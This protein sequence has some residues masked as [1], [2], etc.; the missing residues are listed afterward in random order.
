MSHLNKPLKI[1]LKIIAW[2]L[3]VV[4]VI[5]FAVILTIRSPWGQDLIVTKAVDFVSK[6]IGTKVSI[7]RLFITFS[8]NAY[9]EGVYLE[10]QNQDTLVYSKSLEVGV[11]LIPIIKGEKLNLTKLKW[12][13]LVARVSKDE[14]TAAFNFDYI[15]A[16]F[17]ADST[18]SAPADSSATQPLTIEIGTILLS[19]FDLKFDDPVVGMHAL[20]KL[21]SLNL[22]MDDFDLDAMRFH[23]DELLLEE[24]RVSY[25]QTKPLSPTTDTTSS[26]STLPKIIIDDLK[27]ENLYLAYESIPDRMKADGHI[28][29]L[30]IELPQADLQKQIVRLENFSLVNSNIYYH[31]FLPSQ[32]PA[33]T[34]ASSTAFI[35]PQWD[36]EADKIS[37][38]NNSII[39]KTDSLTNNTKQFDPTN[40]HLAGIR[41]DLKDVKYQPENASLSLSDFSFNEQS[42]FRLKD[43]GVDLALE[44]KSIKLE[45][46]HIATKAN[47]LKGDLQ[48]EYPSI[49]ELIQSPMTSSASIDLSEIQ[50]NL[51]EVL[52]F[53]PELAQNPYIKEMS[54]KNLNGSLRIYGDTSKLS[55]PDFNLRWR[56]QTLISMSGEVAH[57][58][59]TNMLSFDIPNMHF[60]T[61]KKDLLLFVSEADL[62]VNIPRSIDL[63]AEAKGSLQG[64]QAKINLEMPEGK[65]QLD[66][67]FAQKDGI[68]FSSQLSVVDLNVGKII[69]NDQIGILTFDMKAKGDGSSLQNLNGDL[70]TSFQRLELSGYDYSGLFLGGKI[71]QGMANVHLKFNDNNLKMGMQASSRIDSMMQNAQVTLNLEGADLKALNLT[72]EDIRTK[73]NLKANYSTDSTKTAIKA[74]IKDGVAVYKNTTYPFGEFEADAMLANDSTNVVIKSRIIDLQMVSNQGTSDL[75]TSLKRQF[76]YYLT[77]S[78]RVDSVAHPSVTHLEMTLKESPLLSDVLLPGL[79]RLDETYLRMDYIE[80]EH[81][82]EAKLNAPFIDY[83]GSQVSNLMLNVIGDN[84]NLKFDLGWSMIETGPVQIEKTTFTGLMENKKIFIDFEM[85]AD[86]EQMAFVQSEITMTGDSLNY[87]INHEK[88]LLNKKSWSIPAPNQLIVADQYIS[89]RDFTFSQA[90][91]SFS[92]KSKNENNDTHL[93]LAFKNFGLET[94]TSL[95]NPDKPIAKGKIN[96]DLTVEHVFRNL[97]FVALLDI[98]QLEAMGVSLGT[99]NLNARSEDAQAYTANLTVKGANIDLEADANYKLPNELEANMTLRKMSTSIV[100]GF[101]PDLI[102]KSSG[103]ISATMEISG[104]TEDPQY[105]GL[106]SFNEA[107]TSVNMLQTQFTIIK[108]EIAVDNSGI[109][110]DKLTIYDAKENKF[111]LEGSVSTKDMLNPS[112]DLRLSANNFTAIN[113]EKGDNP[114]FFGSFNLSTNLTIKGDMNIPIVNG[115]VEVNKGTEFTFIVPESQLELVER[116][117]VVVFVNRQNPDDILTRSS[118]TSSTSSFTGMDL[119]VELAVNEEAIFNVV[120]DEKTGDNLQIAG[121]GDFSLGLE[122]NGRTTLSG[123]FEVHSGHYEASL[124]GLVKRRFKIADGSTLLWKG[125]P[126]EA[127]MDIRAIYEVKTSAAPLMAVQTAGES[128]AANQKYQQKLNFL[129]YL[130]LEG[131]LLTPE[132]SFNLDMLEEDRGALGGEVYG[133]VQQLNNRE[134]ELNKQV[135]SL[136]VMNRFFPGG[137]SDGSSGGPASIARDNVNKVLSSQLNNFSDKLLGDSGFELDF[138]L[139]SYQNY[140]GDTPQDETQLDI[141]AKKGFFNNRLIVQVGSEVN[142]EGA[143]QQQTQEQANTPMVGNVSVEY[144]IT[145]NGRYRLK[146]FRKNQFESIID[147]QLTITGLGFIFNREFNKFNE[148]FRSQPATKPEEVEVK[149]EEIEEENEK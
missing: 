4:V 127:E 32:S 141:S 10:D 109:N 95:L 77:D 130:N 55:I 59:S 35:W 99:L 52:V 98:T 7:D 22:D 119:D 81:K 120:I 27:I 139:E 47:K 45:N 33:D 29:E 1:I 132:I 65:I 83:S 25:K 41:L 76:G 145:E 36:V 128:T 96:G 122:T 79:E 131:E 24:T 19:D 57:P 15:I 63:R 111:T 108:D 75:T 18:T 147:G 46:L 8:G 134:D 68:S 140:E 97:G 72:T 48:L 101:I 62:G 58:L 14:N 28:G 40:I 82:I 114:L 66:G 115:K 26:T 125:D 87:H 149:P 64:A 51:S 88:L 37:L 39:Y 126:L 42:G 21:K 124:Y 104:S 74:T 105:K 44:S 12:E 117:G 103:H 100:E 43:F 144:L 92:L 50:I 11:E 113:S 53:A 56:S 78:A 138:G 146:G 116:E 2:M 133:T 13:G 71:T 54:K 89:F 17:A 60:A 148:I 93:T 136:L 102:S 34:T 30:L 38:D 6:K 135:F 143:E 121:D 16:A 20:L 90:D 118:D 85:L 61:T 73:F 137:G 67:Q 112:F 123:R 106:I 86:E 31:S 110:L 3:T 91:Q 142:L 9:L 84:Q 107:S 23:I 80:A 70:I 49:A 5:V 129:V 94:F 69:G